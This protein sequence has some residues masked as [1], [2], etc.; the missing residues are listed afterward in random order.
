MGWNDETVSGGKWFKI[1]EG[2]SKEFTVISITEKEAKAPIN[3]LP[4]KETYYLFETD[5]GSLTVN[6]GGMFRALVN[7]GVR[8]GDRV[9]VKYLKKGK[10]GKLS[11]FEVSTISKGDTV[12][13][14]VTEEED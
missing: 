6:N 12:P 14:D 9:I 5:I 2:E 4:N 11:E 1:L 7:A 10:I 3:A 8:E 13:F